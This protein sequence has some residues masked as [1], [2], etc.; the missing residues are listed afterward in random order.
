MVELIDVVLTKERDMRDK[1]IIPTK[2][3]EER[4]SQLYKEAL[5]EIRSYAESIDASPESALGKAR[6]YLLSRWE[7]FTMYINDG[8]IE[9]SNNISE[10][11]IKPFVI[12]RKNFLFNITSDGAQS[13]AIFF[14][15]QQTARAN[16]LDI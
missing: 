4:N 7:V 6:N 15:L 5:E 9:M 10:R 14:S 1:K 11:A 16:M 2:I 13:S 3:E 12:A 8:H